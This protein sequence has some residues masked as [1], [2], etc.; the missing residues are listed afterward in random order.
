M[1]FSVTAITFL[2]CIAGNVATVASAKAP[3][4]QR[5]GG[6]DDKSVS[7]PDTPAGRHA[8]AF[9]SAFNSGDANTMRVFS[10]TRRSK[11]SLESRSMEDRLEQYRQLYDGWGRLTVRGVESIDERTLTLTVKPERGYAGLAM[12]FTCEAAPSDKLAEIRITP[13]I[14]DDGDL[15]ASRENVE[16]S[17]MGD[18]TVLADSLKPL[19]DRF[20]A[21]K[22]KHRFIAILSPT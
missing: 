1:Y 12:T 2:V 18:I 11:S 3:L 9:V 20:N 10:Q 5:D 14:L 6:A 17:T 19:K 22:D 15:E 16:D 7:I 8:K 13:T 21:N 4:V